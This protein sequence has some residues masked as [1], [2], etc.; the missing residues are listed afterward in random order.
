MNIRLVQNVLIVILLF[1]L[2]ESATPW[3]GMVVGISDGDTITVMHRGKPERIRLFG[4]DCPEKDQDFGERAKQFTSQMVFRKI[5]EVFPI[6]ETSYGRSLAWVS[7][8]GISLNK[9][10]VRAGLAWW[11]CRYA[12][13]DSELAELEALA[14]KNKIGLWSHTNT[15]PPW[16]FRRFGR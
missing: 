2:P 3:S 15:V 1:Y 8:N 11:Y 14:R 5:V 12:P 10:L 13:N 7:V 4:I 9:E 16:E 6:G